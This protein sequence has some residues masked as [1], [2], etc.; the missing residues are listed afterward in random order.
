MGFFSKESDEGAKQKLTQAVE[1]ATNFAEHFEEDPGR[2]LAYMAAN[3]PDPLEAV[4]R[5]LA[6]L[7]NSE[8]ISPDQLAVLG[9]DPAEF[10]TLVE[11]LRT[12]NPRETLSHAA[13]VIEAIRDYDQQID[14]IIN[15][16]GV[17]FTSDERTAL[18][19]Q[20]STFASENS[21]TDLKVAYRLM[22]AEGTDPLK[23]A[24]VRHKP[25]YL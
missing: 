13:Q 16:S 19:Q 23:G 5:M 7:V 14:E 8:T 2:T 15:T 12:D 20:L 9:I 10:G 18:L 24:V 1:F 3:A 4:G 11:K 17:T 21:I 25:G 22:K 6:F